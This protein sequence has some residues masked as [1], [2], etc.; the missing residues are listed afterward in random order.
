MRPEL[1]HGKENK[2]YYVA[3]EVKMLS[4]QRCG[5]EERATFL[6]TL[7]EQTGLSFGRNS[8][9]SLFGRQVREHWSRLNHT[10]AGGRRRVPAKD[11]I[12]SLQRSQQRA[13]PGP[14][15][16]KGRG[17]RWKLFMNRRESQIS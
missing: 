8:R 1:L 17:A 13:I 5:L 3:Q 10:R 2:R 9:L 15:W 12:R 14:N 11:T 4:L 6:Y 16:E 7:T